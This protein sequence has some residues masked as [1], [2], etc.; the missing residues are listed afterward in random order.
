MPGF[1][2]EILAPAG[3]FEAL[4]AAVRC[5]ADAIYFGGK[6][7]NA[8]IRADNF[9]DDELPEAVAYCRARGVRA[10]ITLNTLA[11]DSE[12]GQALKTI[13]AACSCGADGLILQDTGLAALAREAAPGMKLH[14]STQMSVQTREGLALLKELGFSRAVLPRELSGPELAALADK[15]PLELEVFVHGAL[16]MSVSGQ[17]YL[18]AFLGSRSGNRGL[19]A[20]P[21]R[22]PF[23]GGD[24]AFALS[25]K[26]LSLLKYLPELAAMG[27]AS[28]KIEGRMKSP[29]YVAA[30]VTACRRVLD[31]QEPDNRVLENAFSRSGF[32]AGY[33][34]GRRGAAMFGVRSAADEHS[35]RME[36]P[37]L[38]KLYSKEAPRVRVDFNLEISETRE[39]SL[40]AAAFS[41]RFTARCENAATR[42]KTVAFTP[43]KAEELLGKCGGTPFFAGSIRAQIPGGLY[44]PDSAVNALRRQAL[45]GLGALLAEP[46]PVPFAAQ[47][48]QSALHRGKEMRLYARFAS[49]AQMPADLSA[50]S[51]VIL[52][53]GAQAETAARN[54]GPGSEVHAEMPRGIFGS[55]RE[56]RADVR[57]A[58]SAGARGMFAGTLDAAAIA[59]E[60][61][62]PFAAGIGTNIFNTPSLEAFAH[63]GAREAVLSFELSLTQ[64]RD[65]GGELPRG[66]AAYGRLPLMLTRNCPA[67]RHDCKNCG[68]EA[69]VKDRLG[70]EFPVVCSRGCSQ[71]LNSR[72]LTL[73]D[74]RADIKNIDF[75]LLYFTVESRAQCAQIIR[76]FTGQQPPRGEFTRGLYYRGAD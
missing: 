63:L 60:E 74:K 5:G 10:Y 31:G 22:L 55:A 3:G 12:I 50:F 72:P 75:L 62:A 26:D 28:L 44:L 9:G 38:R 33:Y 21:C 66:L 30:A 57:S 61:G 16:C 52:P 24:N 41:K 68:D 69:S 46:V 54:A 59:L 18:S 1:K 6:T 65:I 76:D 67:G 25:L 23:R 43:E 71:V 58:L 35:S 14:A 42:A 37:A 8:R 47:A 45:E 53:L 64:A 19:C 73:A 27:I 4:K 29:E 39:V 32:T 17:C 51:K 56:I 7:L 15:P 70:I 40:T 11:R 49:A 20:G 48:R 13:E 36:A 2:P 34:E